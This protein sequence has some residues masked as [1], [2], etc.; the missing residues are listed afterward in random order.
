MV[1]SVLDRRFAGH[2]SVASKRDRNVPPLGSS[3][4]RPDCIKRL[5]A[6]YRILASAGNNLN[7]IAVGNS[8]GII[9][10]GPAEERIVVPRE[11]II[12]RKGNGVARFGLYALRGGTGTA[13]KI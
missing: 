12:G 13:V 11:A 9:V 4:A 5:V 10:R 7:V 2:R 1:V 3:S 8:V 6:C